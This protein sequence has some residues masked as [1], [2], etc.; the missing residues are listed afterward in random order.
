MGSIESA[1][2]AD[3]RF[4]DYNGF[5]NWNPLW[6]CGFPFHLSYTP[7]VP[8]STVVTHWLIPAISLP[9]SYRIV[10]ALAYAFGPATLFLFVKYLTRRES[11]AFAAAVIYSVALMPIYSAVPLG[12]ELIANL[13]YVPYTLI[14]L[15]YFGEGPHILGLT[16]IPLAALAL[17]GEVQHAGVDIQPT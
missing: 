9:Q 6:Y 15:T 2:I 14:A 4:V 1:F 13:N 3:A 11:T 17:A 5:V 16:V 8:F 10:T 7:L 12:A